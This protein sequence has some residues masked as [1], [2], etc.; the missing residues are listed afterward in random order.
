MRKLLVGILAALSIFFTTTKIVQADIKI[1][2]RTI[3]NGQTSEGTTYIKGARQRTE[4]AAEIIS[5]LQ[6]DRGRSIQLNNRAKTYLTNTIGEST[7]VDSSADKTPSPAAAPPPTE[8]KKGGVVTYTNTIVDTGERKQMFGFTARHLKISMTSES[9]PDACNQET[10]RMESDGWYI[11]LQYGVEC[12]IDVP[13]TAP[14]NSGAQDGCRD[15]IK[16]KKDGAAKLGY[17]AMVTTT[18]HLKDGQSFSST[19]EIVALDMT[20]LE[21]ALFEVP[22]DYREA[23]TYAE[24]S[25]VSSATPDDSPGVIDASENNRQPS[26]TAA[27]PKDADSIRI[28]IVAV[29]N[30]TERSFSEAALRDRLISFL[31]DQGVDAISLTAGAESAELAAEAKSKQCDFILYTDVVNLKQSASSKLGG[32]L[33]R[34]S[35][36]AGLGGGK[37]EARLDF[38][39]LIV[40]DLKQVLQSTTSVKEDGGEDSALTVA[41]ESE[42]REVAAEVKKK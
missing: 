37:H 13:N 31:D 35:G 23:K 7:G 33:G 6:C 17:P 18:F 29:N 8:K 32:F 24:L 34:A 15:E 1:T 25:S 4:H 9:S 19:Q 39:L 22:A 21:A 26:A 41:L 28:G 16:F 11:D 2:T 5:L 27:P 10:M 42:A 36:A 3:S 12:P 40:D 30:R 14:M 38:K 20:T